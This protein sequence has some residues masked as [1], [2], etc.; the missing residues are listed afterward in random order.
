MK[1]FG[2]FGRISKTFLFR[3]SVLTLTDTCLIL[4]AKLNTSYI[5]MIIR[6]V[7]RIIHN[8][9]KRYFFSAVI[10]KEK[11]LEQAN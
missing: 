6:I 5:S 1:R 9:T 10:R 4:S 8:D 2:L 7:I 3:F 11:L